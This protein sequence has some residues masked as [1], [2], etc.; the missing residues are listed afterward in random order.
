[1]KNLK[2]GVLKYQRGARYL[3]PLAPLH[4]EMRLVLDSRWLFLEE[5]K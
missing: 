3:H 1:M 5:H 4:P 2:N